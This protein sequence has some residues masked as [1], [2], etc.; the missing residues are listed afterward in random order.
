MAENASY[1]LRL[2][3]TRRLFL[4]LSPQTLDDFLFAGGQY[5]I[6][7]KDNACCPTFS[8]LP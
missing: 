8:G 1:L 6:F 5:S 4:A 3:F 7:S 2:E